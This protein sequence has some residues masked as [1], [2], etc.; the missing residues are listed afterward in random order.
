MSEGL[1]HI[2]WRAIVDN[3]GSYSTSKT[4]VA[5]RYKLYT[6]DFHI[7]ESSRKSKLT[8]TVCLRNASAEM[9]R[10]PMALGIAHLL[11]YNLKHG[12]EGG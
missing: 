5:R 11:A 2:V 10:D 1:E 6:V 4:K 9:A 8:E 12:R 7:R 3:V